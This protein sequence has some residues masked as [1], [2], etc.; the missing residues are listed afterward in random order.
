[1]THLIITNREPSAI[2]DGWIHIVPK[3]ELPNREAGII[4]VLDEEALDAIL[5][6]IGKDRARMGD[7]WPGLYAGEEHW[8]YNDE[9]TSAA[10]AWFKDFQKRED[11]I[12]AS[13][14]GLTDLGRQAVDNQ[15]FKYTSFVADRRDT[16]KLEGD[17]VRIEGVDTIGFTNQA[18]GKELLTPITNREFR[19]G[20]APAAGSNDKQTT[21]R[22]T[23]KSVATKL[24]LSAEASEETILAEV[25][26]VMNR[27]EGLAG[28]VTPIKNRVTALETENATLL[29]EQ[30]DA[31]FATAGIK[32][33]K[34]INR[35]KPLLADPKHFKNRAERVSFIGDLVKPAGRDAGAPGQNRLRNRDTK[36]PDDKSE[37][38]EAGN[39]A[40]AVKA[41]K[42]MNRAGQLQKELPNLSMATAVSMAQQEIENAS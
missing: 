9:K 39:K 18:N 12:W 42:I 29:T 34:I 6:K 2:A 22:T 16:R 40:E 13:A 25:T 15:R 37:G 27:V 10:F 38:G 11:G 31:D 32:D 35:H 17:R 36:A 5:A 19:R 14:K 30:I 21:K 7:K 4:Q 28:E 23:M 3:G 1:M 26:K 24:G 33:E 20:E 8:I 41:T